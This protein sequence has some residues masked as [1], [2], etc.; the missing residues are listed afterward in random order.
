MVRFGLLLA[1]VVC[2]CAALLLWYG[3]KARRAVPT[4]VVVHRRGAASTRAEAI[5][6][7]AAPV[8]VW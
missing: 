4:R 7:L 8:G 3:I 6:E 1:N 5:I 2:V